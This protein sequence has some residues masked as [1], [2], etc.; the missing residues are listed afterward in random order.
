[1][2]GAFIYLF[3][4]YAYVQKGL[5]SAFSAPFTQLLIIKITFHPS[6]E[7]PLKISS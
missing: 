6:A 2:E 7:Q 4:I 3:I 5:G 1:M